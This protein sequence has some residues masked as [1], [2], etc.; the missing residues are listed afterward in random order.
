MNKNT[1]IIDLS[2]YSPLTKDK[3]E[4]LKSHMG[5]ATSAI[6]MKKVKDWWEYGCVKR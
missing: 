5:S 6:D 3:K 1:K 4:I 2:K